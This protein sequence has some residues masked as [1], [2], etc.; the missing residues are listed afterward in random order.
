MTSQSGKQTIGTRTKYAIT[1]QLIEYSVRNTFLQKSCRKGG[2]G[3]SSRP[4][5]DF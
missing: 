1:I 3:I 2:R 4:L 5:F